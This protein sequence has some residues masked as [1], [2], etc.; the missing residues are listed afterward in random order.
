MDK[1]IIENTFIELGMPPGLKG[2]PYI[3][4]AIELLDNPEW[5]NPKWTALYYC[6]SSVYKVTPSSVERAIRNALKVT[7]DRNANYKLIEEYISFSN[8]ENSNSLMQLYTKLK[9]KER[10]SNCVITKFM[11]KQALMEIINS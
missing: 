6:I 8:C 2:F 4:K 7:R 3:V 5:S 9:H 1:I 11:I 10:N